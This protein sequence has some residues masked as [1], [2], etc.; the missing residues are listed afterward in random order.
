VVTPSGAKDI[1][2]S[3]PAQSFAA[4]TSPTVAILP[5]G[6]GKLVN[7]IVLMPPPTPTSV[8]LTNPSARVKAVNA[9]PDST[10]LTFKANGA[11]LLSSVPYTASSSYVV[12]NAGARSFQVEAS[13][14]PGATLTSLSLTLNPAV[15]YTLVAVNNLAQIQLASFADDNTVPLAGFVRVRFANA[16]VGSTSVDAL[17]NFASQA[18]GIG[19]ASASAY[20]QIAAATDYT[21]TFATPGG[22]QTIATLASNETAATNIY[23][24]YLLGTTA[25]PQ[26]KL[27]RDR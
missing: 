22:V 13:N 15:D 26:V 11:A 1:L 12:T 3:A 16:M 25:A 18:P 20:Y 7:V 8:F 4:N 23:T 17:V 5:A 9:V 6:G 2:F 14:V 21:V 10:N 24:F 27:V 19:F